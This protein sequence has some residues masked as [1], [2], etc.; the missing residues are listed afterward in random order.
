MP[1]AGGLVIASDQQT[2]R[3][4]AKLLRDDHRREGGR[5]ALRRRRRLRPD[6]RLR[7]VRRSGGWSR[8]GWCPRAST[9]RG[10]PSGVYATSAST[11]L[12]FA[13]AIGR[14]VRVRRPG[15]TATVF[16]P[17][18]PHLLGLASEMEAQRDH[19]LGR[20]PSRRTG[21]DDELLERA[22]RTEQAS[23]ELEKRFEALSATAEL[24][25]VIFD[26]ASFGTPVQAGT[27][28]EEEYLGLP[29][30]LTAD[31]VS[32]LLARRQAEQQAAAA[33]RRRCRRHRDAARN[34]ARLPP[35]SGG[36]CCAA[37]STGW[38]PRTTT[39]PGC[40]TARSTPSCAG[41]A[42][43]HP[44]PRPPSSSSKSGSPPSRRSEPADP[45]SGK[46]DGAP[47][48]A[49]APSGVAMSSPAQL[50]SRSGFSVSSVPRHGKSGA[51]RDLYRDL[52]QL[53]RVLVRVVSAEDQLSTA[54][55]HDAQLAGRVAPVAP[56]LGARGCHRLRRR[57]EGWGHRLLLLIRHR[58]WAFPGSF[59]SR[60]VQHRVHRLDVP[61]QPWRT[62]VTPSVSRQCRLHCE[63]APPASTT[64][65]RSR[66]RYS[67]I[68]VDPCNRTSATAGRSVTYGAVP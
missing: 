37:S 5:R 10:W 8:Y 41:C 39:G 26:G 47:A 66:H 27:P 65:C 43:G 31:Q 53:C 23:G 57:R 68:R 67:A 20:R 48:E 19:V 16:L 50:L 30:L 59:P 44:A 4:Y 13:Q 3:A 55:E 14:F 1:D 24:D 2:A 11:P 54:C 18:V 60:T 33:R 58:R 32:T 61:V 36:S 21:F 28:E 29:G 35:G 15:E 56:L 45:P 34:R 49:G 9:S 63:P 7:R 52:H 38:S 46:R 40:R 22:N 6:R 17:S 25:Q 64:L 12:F 51:D 42:A 62:E